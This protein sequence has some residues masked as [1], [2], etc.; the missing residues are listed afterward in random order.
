MT[1]HSTFL[2]PDATSA[3]KSREPLR[4]ELSE[5]PGRGSLD[6]GRWPQSRDIDV[7]LADPSNRRSTAPGQG[8]P[9]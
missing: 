6:G 3:Y 1:S 4:L 9:E 5:S 7:E 2:L 8:S